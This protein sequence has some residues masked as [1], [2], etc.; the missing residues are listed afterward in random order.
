MSKRHWKKQL[1]QVFEDLEKTFKL[2]DF[3]WK[4]SLNDWLKFKRKWLK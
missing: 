4:I 3:N 1:E 2:E